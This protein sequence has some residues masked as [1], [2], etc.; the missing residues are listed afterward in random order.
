MFA[1]MM[2]SMKRAEKAAAAGSGGKDPSHVADE[3]LDEEDLIARVRAGQ[4]IH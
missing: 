2:A 4:C 3:D 1:E